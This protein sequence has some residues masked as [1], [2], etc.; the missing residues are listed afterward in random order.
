MRS[1]GSRWI[2]HKRK[3]LQRV[4]DRYGAYINHLCT[5]VEDQ[6]VKASDRA[7]LRGYLKKWKQGKMLIAAAL[8]VD[9]LKAP[10]ILSLCLQ[11]EKLDIVLGIR[12]LLL[13]RKSILA[14]AGQDPLDWP[15][16]KL[17]CSRI[18]VE[19]GE[20]LYQGSV[21]S[22]Y[23]PDLLKS[24]A[25]QAVAD[26][27]R[28]DVKL[29]E[30]LEWSDLEM[31]RSILVFLDTQS[32]RVVAGTEVD[33]LAEIQTAV[34]HIT[35]HFREPLAAK[36]ICFISIPDEL[37]E[38]VTYARKYLSINQESYQK[39]WYK[40]YISPDSAKWPNVLKLCELL[41]S[42][43]FSNAYVE[44]MFSYLKIIKTDRRTNL[45]PD[46][47]SDLLDIQVEGPPLDNY[48]PDQ[49]V[50]LWWEDCTTTRRVN[51][52][53]RNEYKARAVP[54]SQ[55]ELPGPSTASERQHDDVEAVT[56]SLED[57]DEWCEH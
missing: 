33:D 47:M 34:E 21:L 46:T 57:W 35:A 19:D 18:K 4:V 32:W 6:S 11:H 1:V 39:V 36:N 42:L 54:D 50:K 38:A 27:K 17:V 31:L 45:K 41:F 52:A 56:L 55:S 44:R 49:A 7:R 15:T 12:Q 40:L 9:I 23:T 20:S 3:A 48:S 5:L 16:V 26:A 30:R 51:Q 37:E 10:S 14:M 28:L 13:S 43:P 2:A 25:D 8:Y 24:C 29:R 53:P 22:G